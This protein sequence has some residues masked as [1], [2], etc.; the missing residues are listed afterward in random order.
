MT[1]TPPPAAPPATAPLSPTARSTVVRGRGRAATD[2]EALHDLLRQALVCH[3]GVVVGEGP[4]AHPVVVPTAFGW[5]AEGPDAG[6]T[7]YLHGSVA[8]RSLLAAPGA[9][10][11]VTL[12]LLDG[13]VVARSAFHHSV[14]Y[15]S[16]VV[17]GTP[18]VVVDDAERGRALDLLVDQ[19]LPGRAATLRAHTRKELA[20]TAVLALPL[21]EAS[22]KIRVG[23]PV[24]DP[25]DV[26]TGAWAGVLP[27][28]LVAGRPVTTADASGPVP[29]DVSRRATSLAPH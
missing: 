12:T 17:L 3:L 4:R 22:V 11:C 16:A 18:R 27:L 5:D 20:A 2:R 7:L 14:N 10:V 25:E 1:T 15:R 24:D 6:G 19:V 28:L 21:H 23:D 8:S 13:L 29:A 26:G 9:T